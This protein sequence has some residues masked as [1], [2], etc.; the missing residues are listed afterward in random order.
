MP[1]RQPTPL[2]HAPPGYERTYTLAVPGPLDLQFNGPWWNLLAIGSLFT[3]PF[4]VA[5]LRPEYWTLARRFPALALLGWILAWRLSWKRRSWGDR[6]QC[7]AHESTHASLLWLCSR[8]KPKMS[9]RHRDDGYAYAYAPEWYF[10]RNMYLVIALAPAG[11]L[12]AAALVLLRWIPARMLLLV[13]PLVGCMA[14]VNL[15]GSVVDLY[16]ARQLTRR[17]D[18]FLHDDGRVYSIWEPATLE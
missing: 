10:P 8:T 14:A 2:R 13:A 11:L 3:Y 5:L 7:A 4:T 17:P 16:I 15:G 1:A 12:T 6:A 18:A 9:F